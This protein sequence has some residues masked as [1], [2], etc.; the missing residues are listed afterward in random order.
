MQFKFGLHTVLSAIALAAIALPAQAQI[1]QNFDGV[2]PAFMSDYAQVANN[3]AAGEFNIVTNPTLFNAGFA[4]FGD[5]TSGVGNMLVANGST[6]A[7]QDVYRQQITLSGGLFT[8]S[9]FAR[10]AFPQNGPVLQFFVNGVAQGTS[11]AVNSDPAAGFQQ[12][13]AVVAV[14]GGAT[15]FSIRELSLASNGNDFAID[16]I[17]VAVAPEAGTLVYTALGFVSLGV[18]ARRRRAK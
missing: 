13:S 1:V 14:A 11:F 8:F 5:N 6:V 15:T 7:G 10:S 3:T 16:D 4:S 9:A 2:N 18:A 12:F 17:S